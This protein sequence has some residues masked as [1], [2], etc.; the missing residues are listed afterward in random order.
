MSSIL[1]NSH[2][3][4]VRVFKN[5]FQKKKKLVSFSYTQPGDVCPFAALGSDPSPS[6]G[7]VTG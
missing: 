4:T 3:I 6:C 2:L 7:A 5:L 1:Q